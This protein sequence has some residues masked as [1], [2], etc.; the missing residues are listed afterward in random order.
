MAP[1]HSERLNKLAAAL[2][3]AQAQLEPAHVDAV[4]AVGD[5][6]ADGRTY[7]Y[8]TLASVWRAIRGALS[9][10]GLA[11]VQACEP[12][13]AGEVRLVTTLLH[14]SGQW[15]SGVTALPVPVRTPQGYGSALTY[16]RRYGLAAMV[17]LCV[18]R[19]DDAAATGRSSAPSGDAPDSRRTARDAAS[20][21]WWKVPCNQATAAQLQAFM[22][23]Y[24]RAKRVPSVDR[25]DLRRDFEIEGRLVDHFGDTPLG[26]I[27]A[28]ARARRSARAAGDRDA[29]TD[30]DAA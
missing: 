11:V 1:A 18:D 23:A 3:R 29:S 4:A 12:G 17:G 20:G 8:A 26:E 25:D 21:A 15:M 22:R 24:A 9:S 7:P 5:D 14:S 28:R 10:N 19:D 30:S 16:A 2:A 27:V 6:G 13:D